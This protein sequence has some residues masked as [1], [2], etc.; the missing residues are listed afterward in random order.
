[1]SHVFPTT[2]RRLNIA[3]VGTGIAGMSASWLLDQG[4]RITIYEQNARIGG[5]SNTVPGRHRLYRLQ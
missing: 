2:N 1:M 5:H 4:H 3:V